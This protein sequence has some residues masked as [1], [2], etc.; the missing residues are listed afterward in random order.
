MAGFWYLRPGRASVWARQL[1]CVQTWRP[2]P[3]PQLGPRATFPPAG[4]FSAHGFSVPTPVKPSASVPT[5]LKWAQLSSGSRTFCSC[6][7]RAC[8]C[9]QLP[10]TEDLLVYV[11]LCGVCPSRVACQLLPSNLSLKL[12]FGAGSLPEFSACENKRQPQGP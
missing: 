11:S 1:V 4:S 2:V 7:E 3:A 12:C 10:M 6:P 8:S 9:S 5:R